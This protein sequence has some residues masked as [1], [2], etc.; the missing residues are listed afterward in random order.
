MDIIAW[1]VVLEGLLLRSVFGNKQSGLTHMSVLCKAAISRSR[2]WVYGLYRFLHDV[3]TGK[4]S[5]PLFCRC[6]PEEP[7][8]TDVYCGWPC[9]VQ[10]AHVYLLV[11]LVKLTVGSAHSYIMILEWQQA[12]VA[13][14]ASPSTSTLIHLG[15]K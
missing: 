6:W 1:S 9:G 3:Q 12:T 10:S 5:S 8:F 11:A 4:V 15:A 7:L 14:F 2:G 13:C